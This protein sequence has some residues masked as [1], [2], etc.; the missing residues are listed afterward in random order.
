MAYDVFLSHA[1]QD[2]FLADAV[3]HRLEQEGVRCWIAPRDI[4]PGKEWSAEIVHAIRNCQVVVLVYSSATN[5]SPQVTREMG[6]TVQEKKALIPV[7]VEDAE[8]S[9]ALQYYLHAPHWLDAMTEPFD[10]HLDRLMR[11][12]R[13]FLDLEG[14]EGVLDSGTGEEEPA[15]EVA[16]PPDQWRRKR[17]SF[18]QKILDR[19][20]DK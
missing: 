15:Q 17:P 8:M 6:L 9:E 11:A 5:D 2:K 16:L 20:Q 1:F 19:F 18:L 13:G 4:T 14:S 12:V 3:C 10:A 7:R